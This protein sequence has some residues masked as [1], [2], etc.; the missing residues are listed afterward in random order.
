MIKAYW[1][2]R[3]PNLETVPE[4][5][6]DEIEGKLLRYLGTWPEGLSTSRMGA[7]IKSCSRG[8]GYSER[9]YEA[10]LTKL[11]DSGRIAIANG[12]WYLRSKPK[13]ESND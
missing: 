11:R 12:I 10:G 5:A 7:W 8:G 2:Q 3:S 4:P 6:R 9:E 1:R 13:A